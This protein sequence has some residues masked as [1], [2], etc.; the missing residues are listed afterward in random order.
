[1]LKS[2]IKSLLAKKKSIHISDM[3]PNTSLVPRQIWDNYFNW[4]HYSDVWR[5]VSYH[6]IRTLKLP[7]DMWN[8][9]EIIFEHQ[10]EWVLETGTRHGGSAKFFADTLAFRKAQGHVISIDID[11]EARQLD[12]YPGIDFLVGNSAHIDMVNLAQEI[13]PKNRGALFIILDS[14]H[15]ASHV[16]KELEV[17]MPTLK[18]GD[19]LVVEDGCVNGHPVRPEHGPGPLEAVEKWIACNPGKLWHDMKRERKF[20]ATTAPHGYYKV[21][22]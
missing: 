5:S 2:F 7:S 1:M 18:P 10:I 20:G 8:Y 16:Y 9:Q 13:L 11:S 6:G 17:W 14:D 19:Y 4:F 15:T 22:A 12:T 21:I 3:K